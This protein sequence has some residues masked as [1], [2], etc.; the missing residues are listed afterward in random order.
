MGHGIWA[1]SDKVIPPLLINPSKNPRASASNLKKSRLPLLLM[2]AIF[3][4]LGLPSLLRMT[5]LAEVPK[6]NALLG[7]DRKELAVTASALWE[8][9]VSGR[10]Q[11]QPSSMKMPGIPALS[12]YVECVEAKRAGQFSAIKIRFLEEVWKGDGEGGKEGRRRGK[13]YPGRGTA[14][15]KA[16]GGW[17][18]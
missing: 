18:R 13:G 4:G 6:W 3:S 1:K 7:G 8:L 17:R 12:E 10:R 15:D 11:A 9:T 5:Q 16:E 14:T 2:V